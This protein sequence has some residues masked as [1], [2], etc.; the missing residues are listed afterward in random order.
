M[1]RAPTNK[2]ILSGTIERLKGDPKADF[3]LV[4]VYGVLLASR[5]MIP[6]DELSVDDRDLKLSNQRSYIQQ[7]AGPMP[8]YAAVRHEIPIEEVKKDKKISLENLD[9]MKQEAK[10]EAWFQWFEFT[11]YELSCEELEA[12]IP[13]WSIG[14][15]FKQG[16]SKRRDNGLGL[17]ELRVP[18]LMGIWG[19]AFCATLAHYYKEIRPLIKDLTGF[20][21]I[22]D[23]IEGQNDELIKLHPIEPG[24]VPNYAL[25]LNDM[26]P[27]TCPA[28]I[29]KDPYLNL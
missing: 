16:K 19:S 1:T 18:F 5:L 9:V 13:S 2:Y 22:D 29:F 10:K 12:A 26:L 23:L 17:P 21:G 20:E 15:H 27:S 3:G 7:G 28:S 11:P 25:G 6:R 24:Q 4:D 8:I 14:R